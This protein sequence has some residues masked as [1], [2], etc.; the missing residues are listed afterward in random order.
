MWRLKQIKL[1]RKI[2]FI[3]IVCFWSFQGQAQNC[4]ELYKQALQKY[5]DGDVQAA[6][7]LLENCFSAKKLLAK[8][9]RDVKANLYWL[10]TQSSIL[11]K[12][13]NEAKYYLKKMLAIRPYYKPDKDDL[14]DVGNMMKALIVKPRVSLRLMGGLTGSSANVKE[15]YGIFVNGSSGFSEPKTYRKN[16]QIDIMTG[17]E[18][19]FTFNRYVSFGLGVSISTEEYRYK[20]QLNQQTVEYS[21]IESSANKFDTLQTQTYSLNQQYDHTQSLTYIKFPISL[22][23]HPITIGRFEPYAEIGGYTGLLLSANKTVNTTETDT[24]NVDYIGGSLEQTETRTDFFTTNI[25]SIYV[26][27][28]YGWFAGGGVNIKIH[29]T[30]LFVGARFQF[31]LNNVV[32]QESRFNFDDLT[33]DFYDVMDDVSINSGQVFV[34]WS[35]PLFFKAYE[36]DSRKETIKNSKR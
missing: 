36:K 24:Y 14:Q 3:L 28:T 33:Y 11:L 2:I 15:S 31:G 35:I 18:L 21:L 1:M 22:K 25:K 19:Q 17:A 26:L 12:K 9:E 5:Q 7:D 10:G 27:G 13:N 4:N 23:I 32:R 16:P 8:T 29:R 6:Y 20:Y 34:G 30:N